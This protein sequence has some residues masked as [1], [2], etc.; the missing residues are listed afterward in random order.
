VRVFKSGTV[1]HTS[2]FLSRRR[3]ETGR[4]VNAINNPLALP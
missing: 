4:R 1:T 3:G 2:G